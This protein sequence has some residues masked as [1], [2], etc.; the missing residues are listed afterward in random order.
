MEEGRLPEISVG[1]ESVKLGATMDGL[2]HR[3]SFSS[4]EGHEQCKITSL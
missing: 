3:K 4:L 2:A 1:P